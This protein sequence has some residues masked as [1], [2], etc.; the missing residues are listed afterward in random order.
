MNQNDILKEYYKRVCAPLI[1]VNETKL[2]NNHIAK[3]YLY[4]F[5][6]EEELNNFKKI[7]QEYLPYYVRNSDK[8]KTYKIYDGIDDS[9]IKEI[10]DKDSKKIWYGNQTPHRPTNINGIFGELFT[11][12]YIKNITSQY[13]LLAYV[14]KRA[15]SSNDEAK[16]IDIVAC[17]YENDFLEII[18]SEAKFVSN[19]SSAKT[20]L[21]S[22]IS[23]DKNHLNRKTINS[24]GEFIMAYQ[25]EIE[26]YRDT[27][28]NNKI[29]ELNMLVNNEEMGFIE[30][31][32]RTNT[33]VKFIYFA[34][35]QKNINR[36]IE[37]FRE[38]IEELILKFNEQVLQTDIKNYSIEI[39]FIPT[40]SNS[41]ELKS[42]MEEYL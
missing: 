28:L 23:G 39:V 16:G 31:I 40:F 36:D 41:M 9:I 2:P 1:F 37:K 5:S 17:N 10:L 13:P 30:A 34:V 32:N 24:Y 4:D 18:L 19:L 25:P 38:S 21:I 29:Q 35:F 33:K 27:N 20:A 22:D 12:F 8:I 3:V 6:T 14:S 15:Y 42:K 26:Y 7:F 11:D